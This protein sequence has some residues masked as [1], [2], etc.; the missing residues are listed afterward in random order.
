M[1]RGPLR[2]ALMGAVVLVFGLSAV[3]AASASTLYVSSHGRDRNRCTRHR[4]CRTIGHAIKKAHRGDTVSVGRG[5]YREEVKISSPISVIGS[6]NPVIDARGK[7]N[8]VL[9]SG[10]S[11]SGALVKGFVVKN[12]TFEGI[13]AM[14]TANVTIANNTVQNNDQGGKSSHPTGE[15]AA[16][17]NIP[18]DCG[19]GL[20]L[21]TVRQAQV[22]SNTVMNN[23]GG[24]LIT[25]ELGP[26]AFNVISGNKA[27]N[28]VLDCGITLA[29][30]NTRAVSSGGAPQPS[31]A[32]VYDNYIVNNTANGN[33]T[34]GQGGGI[35]IAAP[36]P[37]TGT[38]N[39]VVNGN[40]AND[41]GLAGVTLHSHAPGQY[42]N[43]NIIT[44]NSV[45]NDGVAGNPGGK[46]GDSD[47]GVTNT[48]GILVGSAVTR[49]QGIVVANNAISNV[50]YGVW[51]KNVTPDSVS[52]NV[53]S[54]VTVPV[55]NT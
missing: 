10:S 29:S 23:A 21:M 13:L 25:D 36:G 39:N 41:N 30:H 50:F 24:I 3:A 40:T 48:V 5:T 52:S 7:D 20:H 47:F 45:S 34:Q 44:N 22:L 32:G 17:G 12:A 11:A 55:T 33:G 4:P 8:G 43:G 18:G 6:R 15:C 31:A 2:V 35:L 51:T 9:I 42:L 14:R 54:G 49:L 53:F 1:F 37:G 38:Y 27:L 28:N 46:P 16:V 19:E 26:T